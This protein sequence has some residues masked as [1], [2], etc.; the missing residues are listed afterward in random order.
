M[1]KNN[2]QLNIGIE[3]CAVWIQ[4]LFLPSGFD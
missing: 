2:A 3:K 1:I 4:K